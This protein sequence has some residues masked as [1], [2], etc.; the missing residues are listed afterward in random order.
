VT[1]LTFIPICSRAYVLSVLLCDYYLVRRGNLHIPSLFDADGNT[2]NPN[3]VYMHY[4]VGFNL[5]GLVSWLA[6][7]AVP[8]PGL[9]LSYL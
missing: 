6:G 2:L 3:G 5:V 4:P 1:P 7:I 9:C 8:L